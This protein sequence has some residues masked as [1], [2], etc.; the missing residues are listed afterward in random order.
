MAKD[1]LSEMI[2]ARTAKN[3]EFPR[4]VEEAEFRRATAR[5]LVAKH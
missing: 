1:F 5:R 3:A 4:L 2:A